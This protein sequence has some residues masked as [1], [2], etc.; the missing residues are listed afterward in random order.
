[1]AGGVIGGKNSGVVN[2]CVD[3][4]GGLRIDHQVIYLAAIRTAGCPTVDPLDD[5]E[6][7]RK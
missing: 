6:G 2:C 5:R 3:R 1:M 7:V 4:G